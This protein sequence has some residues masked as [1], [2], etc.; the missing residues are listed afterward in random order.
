MRGRAN[1]A[2]YEAIFKTIRTE[3]KERKDC[4]DQYTS[5]HRVEAQIS[6]RPYKPAISPGGNHVLAYK[7]ATSMKD[8]LA[9]YNRRRF[10]IENEAE[11]RLL[12]EDI[13]IWAM[14]AN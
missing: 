9:K 5:V 2:K 11:C 8:R 10:T 4:R 13:E 6:G 3:A 14:G 7:M 1:L 12:I